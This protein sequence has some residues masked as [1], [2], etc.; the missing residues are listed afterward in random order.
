VDIDKQK[1]QVYLELL[2]SSSTMPIIVNIKG[3]RKIEGK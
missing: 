2:D 3:I 1:G